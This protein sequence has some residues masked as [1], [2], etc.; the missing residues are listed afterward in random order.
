MCHN[1]F[2]L[3]VNIVVVVVVKGPFKI[4]VKVRRESIG[5]CFLKM[6]LCNF[7]I[8]PLYSCIFPKERRGDEGVDLS[9]RNYILGPMKEPNNEFSL[10]EIV[11]F[12]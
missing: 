3:I 11:S 12:P 5:C 4:K 2:K 8:H 7:H 10:H 6:L 9:C 1:T